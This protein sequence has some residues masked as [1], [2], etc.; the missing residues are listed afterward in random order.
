MTKDNI[1]DIERKFLID[2]IEDFKKLE[3]DLEDCLSQVKTKLSIKE[4]ELIAMM[5]PY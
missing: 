1:K 2:D 5:R 3:G 4:R